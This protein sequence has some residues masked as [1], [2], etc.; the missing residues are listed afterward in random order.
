MAKGESLDA[1]VASRSDLGRFPV[2][3]L[4]GEAEATGIDIYFAIDS[5]DTQLRP[6]EL[7]PLNLSL[8]AEN[9]VYA[10][11][12][13]AIYGNS[14]IYLVADDRLRAIDVTSVGQ[15]R[16]ASGNVQVLIRSDDI[17]DG[18]RIS[19]THLPNA[20]SGLKVKTGDN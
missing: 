15:T 1:S 20:M 10:V 9:D 17:R 3:R 2:V 5:I 13:Q 12:H 4:A 8:P 11:P 19:V 6:G 14:R 7:L 18:D 16:D